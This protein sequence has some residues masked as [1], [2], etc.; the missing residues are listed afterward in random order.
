MAWW[1]QSLYDTC[2]LITLDKLLL[3]RAT[4]ARH[5]PKSVLALEKSFSA[6]QL[7]V[8]TAKRMRRRVT[9]QEL[10]STQDLATVFTS[11]ELSPALADVDKLVFATAVHFQLSVVTADRRLGRAVR[12]VGL[13]VIDLASI[14]REL[15]HAKRL[16]ASGCEQLLAGLAKRNDLLLGTPS[17]TWAELQSHSFPDRPT[18]PPR[19]K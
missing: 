19:K 9:I 7:R 14:L 17:P 1:K 3:E 15:V 4:M 12:D 8:Q 11:T 6:D 2:S 16:S 10:P 5:F 13:Q 18:T